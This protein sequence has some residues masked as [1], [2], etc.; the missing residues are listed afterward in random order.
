MVFSLKYQTSPRFIVNTTPRKSPPKKIPTKSVGVFVFQLSLCSHG[1]ATMISPRSSWSWYSFHFD[2]IAHYVQWEEEK[3]VLKRRVWPTP[4]PEFSDCGTF[5][6][7]QEGSAEAHRTSNLQKFE[8]Q[9]QL[10]KPC[11][12]FAHSRNSLFYFPSLSRIWS[13]FVR[14]SRDAFL[15]MGLGRLQL[16]VGQ[17]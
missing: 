15:L 16:T 9:A 1:G 17:K 12:F 2:F 11:K 14:V 13:G 7:L 4:P 6:V 3:S 8:N 5:G 10:F